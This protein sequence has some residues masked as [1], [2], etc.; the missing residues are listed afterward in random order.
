MTEDGTSFSERQK[1]VFGL[2]LLVKFFVV[3][4]VAKQVASF[5]TAYASRYPIDNNLNLD[6][7]DML[8]G[9]IMFV[10]FTDMHNFYTVRRLTV[11]GSAFRRLMILSF[12]D[13]LMAPLAVLLLVGYNNL[14]S[15]Q[16]LSASDSMNPGWFVVLAV[17][18]NLVFGYFVKRGRVAGS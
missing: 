5:I 15:G 7:T 6:V 16:K 4:A 13:F 17:L 11:P 8:L 3:L 9:A 14:Q 18:K 12:L 1:I 10:V 2:W